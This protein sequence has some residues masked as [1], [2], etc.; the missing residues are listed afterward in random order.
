MSLITEIAQY[1][2]N[3]GI[4]TF[5][6]S[7]TTGNIFIASLPQT[8][9]TCISIYPNGGLPAD[10]KMSYDKPTIMILIRGTTNPIIAETLAQQIYD[11]L[12]GFHHNTFVESGLWILSCLA[13]QSA[14]NWLNVDEN[15]RH[16][17]ARPS[18][19]N[20]DRRRQW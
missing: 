12:H 18:T 7:G 17:F 11:Q 2:D 16:E 5:D 15:G 14:P 19:T 20:G 6:E 4:G 1:L 9:D 13:A 3:E 10:S 8:P